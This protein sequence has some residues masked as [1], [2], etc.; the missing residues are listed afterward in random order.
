MW[1]YALTIFLSA[2]L[3]FQVQPLI[4]K[5]ILPWFGGGAT[6]WTACMLFFQ[7]V[8]LA[9]YAYAH[10]LRSRLAE[11]G[12][13]LVH[14]ALVAGALAL[15]PI[16]PA[17]GWSPEGGGDPTWR[18]LVALAASVGLPYFALSATSPLLQAWFSVAHPQASPY[19][20]Y[21]LS[22]AGSLLALASYPFIV[23][24]ALRLTTQA[25]VWSAAFAAFGVLCGGCAL[26][27]WRA[28]PAA[29]SPDGPRPGLVTRLLW[30]ALA[31]CGSVL[32]L[33]VT[34][35]ET[36]GVG[37]EPFLWILP[38]SL[39]L[40]SFILC[41]ESERTYW[42]PLF[43][44][45]L[46]PAVAGMIALLCENVYAPI[47]WQIIGYNG[48]LFV[49]CMVCHGELARLKPRPRYLTSF[50]LT[51][52]AGGAVGGLFVAVV[53]PLVFHE[54]FELHIGLWT[55]LA[56]AAAAFWHEQSP[57]RRW[58]PR[59]AFPLFGLGVL[60]VLVGAGVV[61]VM[62]ARE[63]IRYSLSASRNFYGVLQV[64]EYNA[65]DP[66]QHHYV[67]SHGRV[68]HGC[69]YTSESL[70]YVPTTYYGANSGIGLALL[71]RRPDL[72]MRIGVV[73][74]GTGTLATYGRK[75]DTFRFYE[76]NPEVRR[77]ATSR[78]TH[79][80][81]SAARCEVVLGDARL[82]LE[83]EPPQAFDVLALDAFTSDAIPVHLLTC[84]AF[85]IY[86]RHLKADG[87]LVVH[88]SNRF[89]DLQPVVL[90]LAEHLGMAAAVIDDQN[91]DDAEE[92]CAST[93]VLVTQ[94]RNF[95]ERRAIRDATS[96]PGEKPGA[97]RLWTD[98]YSDLL[99]ILK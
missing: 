42:R 58:K 57:R 16:A 37:P 12:Q 85:E 51:S 93:W 56:L 48:G 67:L 70:R 29:E 64:T 9:G 59:W 33:A 1:L 73:G 91:P 83:R 45:L 30:L 36:S 43:W 25:V 79:L 63:E 55:C 20:L 65:E 82:S 32:L 72:P 8:L 18:I 40:L 4:G 54:Y 31:A 50:Y 69:Q 44:G 98:Q 5:W 7:T 13:A 34:N 53:A 68:M 97:L 66:E 89:L 3:L 96:Q 80:A 52:A 10:L 41:F 28:R 61:L 71:N 76:I 2:F 87:V 11:R 74:L 26:K 75:G 94:D 92:Y 88:I 27:A 46:A 86:R 14:L 81:D 6:V 62:E 84:E 21:A 23:E 19:R 47:I 78:F 22:N 90:G 38:F 35:Q 49:C 17:A 99:R 60:A 15:L 77:L 24:P 95:L 39:Y